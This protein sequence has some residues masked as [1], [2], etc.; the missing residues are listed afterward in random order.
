VAA[1]VGSHAEPTIAGT[2]VAT[3]R[4][5]VNAWLVVVMFNLVLS[6]LLFR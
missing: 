4:G 5:V 2:S 6:A 1:F 3:T